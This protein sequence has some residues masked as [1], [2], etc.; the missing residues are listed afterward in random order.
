MKQK[1]YYNHV[2]I[3]LSVFFV[4]LLLM[5]GLMVSKWDNTIPLDVTIILILVMGC[6]H[7]M[8]L[9]MMF[10]RPVV[11]KIM[12]DSITL[13][14]VYK[15]RKILLSEIGLVEFPYWT[16]LEDSTSLCHR[17]LLKD[18]DEV[19]IYNKMYV[20]FNDFIKR[21]EDYKRQNGLADEALLQQVTERPFKRMERK[22]YYSKF[23]LI[24]GLYLTVMAMFYY[25]Y[26]LG[27]NYSTGKFVSCN[28]AFAL[29]LVLLFKE[30]CLR[31]FAV[32]LE[33]DRL[34]LRYASLKQR[35]ILFSE[36][37]SVEYPYRTDPDNRRT[38]C[39]RLVLNDGDEVI[40]YTQYMGFRNFHKEWECYKKENGY[41][42]Q[43]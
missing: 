11:I 35:E 36:I 29:L 37:A 3:I 20:D 30:L 24:G 19:F 39:H 15:K 13:N 33:E 41:E 12:E 14:H 31:P 40:I 26:M 42:Q 32:S 7:L 38:L 17:I 5:S 28:V 21:W 18:G 34:V 4:F 25:F 6:I 2:S 9:Y 1:T 8:F 10:S 27:T 43:Q 23:L 22:T 16:K